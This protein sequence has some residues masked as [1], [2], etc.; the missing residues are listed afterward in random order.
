MDNRIYDSMMALFSVCDGAKTKDRAGFNRFD[1]PIARALLTGEWSDMKAASAYKLLRKYKGQLAGFGFD[2]D[3]FEVPDYKVTAQ[4]LIYVR[5]GEDVFSVK[6]QSKK[7]FYDI[8]NAVKALPHARGAKDPEFRWKVPNTEEGKTALVALAQAFEFEMSPKAVELLAAEAIEIEVIRTVEGFGDDRYLVKWSDRDNKLLG[9][10]QAL[11]KHTRYFRPESSGWVCTVTKEFLELLEAH[12]I[13]GREL[14][15]IPASLIAKQEREAARFTEEY[16]KRLKK[17]TKKLLP[18]QVDAVRAQTLAVLKGSALDAS[19][20]GTG[21]TY[22]TLAVFFVLNRPVYVVCPKAVIPSWK[23]AAKYLG[24]TIHGIINYELITRGNHEAQRLTRKN[25]KGEQEEFFKWTLPADVAI[26]F[27]ECHRLKDAT[28]LNNK[29]GIAAL[30]DGYT[31]LGLSATAADNPLQMKFSGLLTGLFDGPHSFWN[32]AK[33]NGVVKARYG[34]EYTGGKVG[35]ARI[36]KRIFPERGNRLRIADLGDAFPESQICAELYD[37]NGAAGKINAI[38]EEMD[39]ELRQL[40]K[41]SKT[42]KSPT[43]PLTVRLRARQQVEL[44]KVPA[45]ASMVEDAIEEGM[46][47]AVFVNF[48]ETMDALIKKLGTDCVI[49]GDQSADERERN[50]QDFQSD[51]EQVIIANIRAGGVGVS[52]HGTPESR[53]RLAIICPTDSGQDLKQALGRVWR[54]NGAKSIQRIFFAADTVEETV[55]ANVRAKIER[56]DTLNDGDLATEVAF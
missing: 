37:M 43:L 31:V 6:F 51:R 47:V 10:L 54:A 17:I 18:Y 5:D 14:V 36:H 25:Y 48:N 33:D 1:N 42:D 16:E 32:W 22:V 45:L 53:M 24:V 19:D 38:Y 4:K 3:S 29:L 21:K 23:R 41:K 9:D 40:A 13:K 44:L 15:Q 11:P 12:D 52:L 35:L 46:S 20:T 8:L 30:V 27:D 50:I 34:H 49:R 2:Y 56:I 28:T 7:N 39:R 26:I 55:C